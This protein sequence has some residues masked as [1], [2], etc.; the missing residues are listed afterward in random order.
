MLLWNIF[1]S[2]MV[3]HPISL[4]WSIISIFSGGSQNWHPEGPHAKSPLKG[5]LVHS[6]EQ[7]LKMLGWDAEE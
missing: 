6:I 2:I 1:D 3:Q 5:L 4:P 7:V